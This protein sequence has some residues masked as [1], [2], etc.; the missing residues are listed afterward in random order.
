MGDGDLLA[1]HLAHH[2]GRAPRN[3]GRM[4]DDDDGDP[5]AHSGCSATSHAAWT[6]SAL[7]CAPGS[8]WPMLRSP[9]SAERRG[10]KACVCPCRYRW[11]PTPS[12]KNK[13]TTTR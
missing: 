11:S 4:R 8:R 10:G 13:K 3:V 2:V 6:N 9:R 1:H 5:T 12:K 7:D